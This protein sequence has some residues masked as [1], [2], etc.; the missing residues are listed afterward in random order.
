MATM[1]ISNLPSQKYRRKPVTS[2][3]EQA[4][5]ALSTVV[6]RWQYDLGW[7]YGLSESDRVRNFKKVLR[8][9]ILSHTL[10]QLADMA[11]NII[12]NV[13]FA[14]YHEDLT[15]ITFSLDMGTS[16]NMENVFY[17]CEGD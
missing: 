13:N 5:K 1:D 2:L 3:H 15:R 10:Q 11:D 4:L 12:D 17:G 6:G 14:V 16:E 8:A 9:Y 7:R